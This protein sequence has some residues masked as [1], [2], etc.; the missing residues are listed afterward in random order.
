MT[1]KELIE[2]VCAGSPS[3]LKQPLLVQHW[4][5]LP[6]AGGI[7]TQ[8][9]GY[10]GFPNRYTMLVITQLSGNTPTVQW[11]EGSNLEYLLTLSSRATLDCDIR[12]KET[13]EAD[14]WTTEL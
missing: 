4:W 9:R 13:E 7:A 14:E 10:E 6:P 1:L 12:I 11:F 3:F 5:Y 8:L 2:Q